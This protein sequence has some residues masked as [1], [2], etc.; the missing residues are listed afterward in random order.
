[1]NVFD[2]GYTG[3]GNQYWANADNVDNIFRYLPAD[4]NKWNV[5]KYFIVDRDKRLSV[6]TEMSV[7]EEKIVREL[8][9]T[10]F[11]KKELVDLIEKVGFSTYNFYYPF[12]G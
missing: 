6:S 12:Y 8:L 3:N 5:L 9:S 4:L 7:K 11:T 10:R 2:N 1:M